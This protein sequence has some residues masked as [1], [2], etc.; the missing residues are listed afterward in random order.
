MSA[1]PP[2]GPR[3]TAWGRLNHHHWRADPPGFLRMIAERHGDIVGFDLGRAPCILVN[4]ASAV[5]ALFFGHGDCLHKPEFVKS[6][7]RGHWGDGLTTLEEEAWRTQRRRMRPA[8]AP[9]ALEAHLA[10]VARCT[11]AMLAGWGEGGIIDLGSA[12]RMLTARIAARRV[13]DADI[14]GYGPAAGCAGLIPVE[15]AIGE[16]HV[17]VPGGDLQAPLT[18]TRPRA[19]RRMDR[20]VALLE[21]RLAGGE[22]RGDLLSA[23]LRGQ[24]GTATGATREAILGE[25]IQLLYSGHLTIPQSLVTFWRDVAAHG[26]GERLAAEAADLCAGGVPDPAAL[27]RSYG[28]AAL[29]ESMRMRPAATFLFREVV[30]PFSLGGFGFAPGSLVWVS[31]MLLHHDARYHPT[32]ERFLPERFDGSPAGVM[33]PGAYLPFGL[34]PRQCIAMQHVLHQM[35]LIIALVARRCTLVPSAG[36]AH[37]THA[38]APALFRFARIPLPVA[39]EAR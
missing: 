29:K 16:D 32:P 5:R 22:D 37:A 19:P 28:L 17:G 12:L 23:L 7:N 2:P 4:E 20:V 13:L 9:A 3:G 1:P 6:S 39:S 31:P 30:R 25:A 15:E 36:S 10:V 21:A 14:E 38:D 27:A 24:D 8:F 26:I 11:E 33:T 35:A 18:M 34:G